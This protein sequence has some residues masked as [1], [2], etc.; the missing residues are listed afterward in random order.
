MWRTGLAAPRHV[1]SS[2][3]RA[4][5]RVPCTG[6]QI[7]NHCATR[8]AQPFCFYCQPPCP[9]VAGQGR[10]RIPAP[11]LI[12]PDSG[13]RE[14]IHTGS[15]PCFHHWHVWPL[16]GCAL[17]IFWCAACSHDGPALEGG[18]VHAPWGWRDPQRTC[19]SCSCLWEGQAA[20]ESCRQ[21]GARPIF[22]QNIHKECHH[23]LR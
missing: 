4:R 11:S 22:F 7:L 13:P 3:T 20:P 16:P 12:C 18:T 21:M 9:W 14:A 15:G 5:T 10:R 8:E 1:G 2:Q 6:R 23:L 17:P 19:N